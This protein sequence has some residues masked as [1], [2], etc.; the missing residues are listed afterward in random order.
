MTLDSKIQRWDTAIRVNKCLP[1]GVPV[2]NPSSP[3]FSVI[4]QLDGSLQGLSGFVNDAVANLETT[5]EMLMNKQWHTRFEKY[6]STAAECGINEHTCS[7]NPHIN[8]HTA[9]IS[10]RKFVEINVFPHDNTIQII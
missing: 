5:G 6:W 1:V 9:D 4:D 7:F 8:P 10:S 3:F 2:H